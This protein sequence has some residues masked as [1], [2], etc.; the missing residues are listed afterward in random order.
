MDNCLSSQGIKTPPYLLNPSDLGIPRK[1]GIYR[2]RTSNCRW[3]I[4]E[5]G[6]SHMHLTG[7]NEVSLE[8][9]SPHKDFDISHAHIGRS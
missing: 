8:P 5:P 6:G 9:H 1:A 2:V 3:Y 4:L 7:Q